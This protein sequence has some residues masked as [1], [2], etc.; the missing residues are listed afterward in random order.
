MEPISCP[1]KIGVI[2]NH[3]NSMIFRTVFGA[4]P[5]FWPMARVSSE[6][7]LGTC[8]RVQPRPQTLFTDIQFVRPQLS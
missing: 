2:H 5:L 7:P 4:A 6:S 1:T 8:P 3:Q